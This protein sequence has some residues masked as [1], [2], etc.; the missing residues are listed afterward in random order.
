MNDEHARVEFLDLMRRLER[1][2]EHVLQV[3]ALA[4]RLFDTLSPLHN[5]GPAERLLLEAA[6]CLHDTGWSVVKDGSGHHKESARLIRTHPW[7]QFP[8][9]D[10][11]VIAQV[12]RYHRK[13]V[14]GAEH[15]EFIALN[16]HDRA[17][18]QQLAAIL[19]LADALDRSHLQRVKQIDVEISESRILFKLKTAKRVE[20]EILA[21]QKKGNLAVALWNRALEFEEVFG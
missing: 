6:S 15:P 3:T 7:Q 12:A 18:V 9:S 19:R 21:A 4:L 17:T 14:P 16:E 13:A 11:E 2:P 5:L 10:V 8:P 20:V 1:E